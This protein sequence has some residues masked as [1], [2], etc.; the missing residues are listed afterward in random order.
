M[1]KAAQKKAIA[2]ESG[3]INVILMNGTNIGYWNGPTHEHRYR[4]TLFLALTI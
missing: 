1:A 3:F 4:S 2:G